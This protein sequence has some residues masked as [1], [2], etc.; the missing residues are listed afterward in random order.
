[1][2]QLSV[3]EQKIADFIYSHPD[4][5]VIILKNNGYRIS[6]KTATLSKINKLVYKAIFIDNNNAFANDLD[7]AINNEGYSGFVVMAVV[8]IAS[9]LISGIFGAKKAKKERELQKNIAL[10]Q[11]SQNEMLVMEKL[12]AES[13]TNRTQILSNSLLAY[14]D[15]LQNQSTIRLKDTWMYVVGLGISIGIVYGVFLLS[16][17]E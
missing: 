2:E 7:N 6:M 1:M 5:V 15:T 14:R 11:I 12:R 10:A 13:E 16:E 9:S 3:E 8:G 4:L 17:K